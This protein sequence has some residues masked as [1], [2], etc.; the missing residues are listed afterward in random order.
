MQLAIGD[1]GTGWSSLTLSETFSDRQVLKIDKSFVDEITTASG[2]AP[3][4]ARD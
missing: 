4:Q 2:E 3:R 1:F